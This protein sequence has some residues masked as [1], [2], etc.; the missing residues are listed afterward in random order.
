MDNDWDSTAFL[1]FL[2]ALDAGMEILALAS[3]TCDSWVDQT[4]LHAV[5]S[6]DPSDEKRRANA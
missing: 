5:R 1:P 3:D 6:H 4:T 2:L